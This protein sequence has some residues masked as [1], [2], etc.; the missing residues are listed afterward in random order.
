MN[1]SLHSLLLASAAILV[2]PGKALAQSSPEPEQFI[3]MGLK[4]EPAYDG[5]RGSDWQVVP[6]VRYEG[7]HLF[8]R[9]SQGFPEAG[10]FVQPFA[11]V[12]LGASLSLADGRKVSDAG[13]PGVR[14]I[15]DQGQTTSLG[16]F[17]ELRT[18]A[19]PV[20][21][22]VTARWRE[23]LQSGRGAEADMRLAFGLYGS[24]K[25]RLQG[26][27][28]LTWANADALAGAYGISAAQSG[29]SGLAA[30]R[31]GSG[32]RHASLGLRGQWDLRPYWSVVG[33]LERRR[34]SDRVTSSPLV[35]AK[36][37]AT[38]TVGLVYRF[39]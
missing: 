7:R 37:A 31:P 30:Y 24:A 26:Y 34:L 8:A 35:A 19:G 18:Q 27:G 32:L 39:R 28:Q 6:I 23:A 12:R 17:I 33:V 38:A 36:S 9:T 5:A 20:P 29:A 13:L 25:V 21:L 10:A 2:M 11:G 22:E 3:G 4:R 16:P 15:E 1:P 14:G